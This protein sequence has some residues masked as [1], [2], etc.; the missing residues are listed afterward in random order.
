MTSDFVEVPATAL[1]ISKRGL[2]YG[3]GINDSEYK[4]ALTE[5]GKII[6]RCPFYRT[7]VSMIERCYY[8][9]FQEVQPTYIG[10]FV[11]DDWLLFSSFREWMKTQD[12]KGKDLDKD[13]KIPGNKEYSPRTC[14]FVSGS[15]NRL[16]SNQPKRRGK[17][18]IGVSFDKSLKKFASKCSH[19]SRQSHLGYFSTPEE[20]SEVYVK[21]KIQ[22]IESYM[23]EYPDLKKGLESFIKSLREGTL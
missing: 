17:W 5:N 18:P 3:A 12:W 14:V 21:Y 13:I 10:C 22:I 16:F 4:I 6:D 20:A 15:L 8:G 23:P 1:S 11:H 7:W 9:K 19:N 2:V